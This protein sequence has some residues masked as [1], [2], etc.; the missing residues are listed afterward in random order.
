[1]KAVVQRVSAAQVRVDGKVVGKIGE[2]LLIL[3][4]V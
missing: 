1:M 3:L 2:G 4:G